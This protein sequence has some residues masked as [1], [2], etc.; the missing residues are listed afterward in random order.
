MSGPGADAAC[1]IYADEMARFGF[2]LG[3]WS[4]FLCPVELIPDFDRHI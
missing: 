3:L 1:H 4:V 2:G